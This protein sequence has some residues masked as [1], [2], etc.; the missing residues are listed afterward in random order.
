MHVQLLAGRL[1]AALGVRKVLVG[2]IQAGQALVE[3]G[4]SVPGPQR[5]AFL[6]V[7]A[8]LPGFGLKG[9]SRRSRRASRSVSTTCAPAARS[10]GTVSVPTAECRVR[11]TMLSNAKVRS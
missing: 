10:T 7:L 6:P 4:L 11:A 8:Q 1:E 3:A 9:L 2:S 5:F